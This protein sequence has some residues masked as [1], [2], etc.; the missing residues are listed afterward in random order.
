MFLANFIRNIFFLNI[1]I[2]T[3]FGTTSLITVFI[4]FP[5]IFFFGL[6]FIIEFMVNENDLRPYSGEK[7]AT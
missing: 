6:K 3:V 2:S 4:P 7:D 1:A 5:S